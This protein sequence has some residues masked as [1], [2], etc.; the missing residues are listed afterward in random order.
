MY[1][2]LGLS[3][4]I[5][6]YSRMPVMIPIF[7]LLSVKIELLIQNQ[8]YPQIFVGW[9]GFIIKLTQSRICIVRSLNNG[10]LH[11]SEPE[12]LFVGYCLVYYVHW[13]KKT[14]HTVGNAIPGNRGLHKSRGG[15]ASTSKE[16]LVFWSHC[17]PEEVRWL[18]AYGFCS[19]TFPK[20]WTI[21]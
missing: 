3:W 4:I 17:L 8:M 7:C 1:C 12:S 15:K 11:L 13:C 16:G 20:W 10:S 14:W 6:C 18:T 5:P 9:L 2:S 21:T 19:L